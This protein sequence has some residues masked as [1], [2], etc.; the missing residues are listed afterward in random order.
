MKT[1]TRLVTLVASAAA[2]LITGFT[3]CE[4]KTIQFSGY[5]WTVTSGTDRGPGP[6]NWDENNVWVDRNGY[7]HL[8]L[9]KRGNQWYC[10][11]VAT[12]A[13]R[14]FVRYQFQVIGQ[15][16]KLDP[17]V[18]FGLFNYPTPDVGPDRTNEIDI[19]FAKW[20]NATAPI[21]NY[22]VWPAITGLNR[23]Y[24]RFSV[25]LNGSYTTHRFTWTAAS[26]FFQSLNG[27]YDDDTNQFE[28]W[29]YQPSD[30][31]NYIGQQPVPVHINL[32]LFKGRPPTNGLEVEVIVSSFK[33]IP[34]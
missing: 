12:T 7:L 9:T 8:K 28:S 15:L 26:V 21:G 27:H 1:T 13:R 17:N 18:V 16:D 2:L 33:F 11:E 31:A 30:P 6:N 3:P 20:G 10:S 19:E 5:D 23:T 22:T 14:G 24:S 25:N 29:L 32:W 34:M 4:A